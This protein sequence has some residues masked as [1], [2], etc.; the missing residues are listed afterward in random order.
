MSF[1]FLSFYQH[2]SICFNWTPLSL[3]NNY[4]GKYYIGFFPSYSVNIAA[5]ES[6]LYI[7]R[8]TLV[9]NIEEDISRG[10]RGLTYI[11]YKNH[12]VLILFNRDNIVLIFNIN[13]INVLLNAILF[14]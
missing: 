4:D 11:R 1:F 9:I 3:R 10:R 2:V 14:K 12:T 5:N 6:T 8:I 13:N 7:E